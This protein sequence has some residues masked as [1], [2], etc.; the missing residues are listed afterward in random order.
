M[1]K[2]IPRLT[3]LT[4]TSK[5]FFSKQV[6]FTFIKRDGTKREVVAKE[7]QHILEVAK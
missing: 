5:S 6:K 1:L 4:H 7:G 3:T 2:Y